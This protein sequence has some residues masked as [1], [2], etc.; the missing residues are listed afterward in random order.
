MADVESSPLVLPAS[1]YPTGW[2]Q[3]GWGDELAPG[4]V[5]HL[6][7]FNQDIVLWR[8]ASG[9]AYAADAHCLHLGAN[10]GV[11]GSTDGDDVVCPWH[12]WHWNGEGRNTLIPRSSQQCKENLRLRTWHLREWYGAIILWHD[13]AGRDP[14][15]EP[16]IAPPLESAEFFPFLPQMRV[17]HRIRA[18]PQ[19]VIENAADLFHVEFVHGGTP[20][21]VMRFEFDGNLFMVDLKLTFGSGKESSWLTPDGAITGVVESRSWGV[22]MTWLQFPPSLMPAVQ[23]TNVTPVDDDYSDYYFCMTTPRQ[24]GDTSEAPSAPMQRLID[25]QMKVIEQDFFTWENMKVLHQPN[26]AP[27]E[28]KNYGALR[29]WCRQFYPELEANVDVRSSA[30]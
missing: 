18:H 27:E 11:K 19:V 14:L 25:F 2:F 7:Y 5:Q 23:F 16:E 8:G 20:A 24:E 22:G 17:V 28:A 26:F 3:V 29:R 6:R 9:Q 12:G 15:W 1:R 13:L 21:E 30:P 4:G 10:I